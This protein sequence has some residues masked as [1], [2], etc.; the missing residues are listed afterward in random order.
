MKRNTLI[1]P[2]AFLQI[3]IARLF[4]ERHNLLP[5]AFLALDQ[6]KDILGFLRLG[7]EVF[8]L[9]GDEGILEELDAY[10]Y[11]EQA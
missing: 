2:V 8:H 9:S 5:D 7:Y 10:V 6:Q 1:D 3:H 11:R 4:M